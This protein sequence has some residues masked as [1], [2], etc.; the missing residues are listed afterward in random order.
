MHNSDF[1][2]K[3]LHKQHGKGQ[4]GPVACHSSKPPISGPP[5][6]R[7]R[8]PC[9]CPVV[10]RWILAPLHALIAKQKMALDPEVSR[11]PPCAVRVGWDI[12]TRVTQR[13]ATTTNVRCAPK[14]LLATPLGSTEA[15]SS[16]N[17]VVPRIPRP[18]NLV[19]AYMRNPAIRLLAYDSELVVN[20]LLS[21]LMVHRGSRRGRHALRGG[22]RRTKMWVA[23]LSC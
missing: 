13:P 9:A 23:Y 15:R 1:P 21:Q 14:V 7:R 11:A 22:P 10:S 6:V 2:I 18:H 5:R 8:A 16:S 4:V 17:Q 12:S 20:P 3:L 19:R